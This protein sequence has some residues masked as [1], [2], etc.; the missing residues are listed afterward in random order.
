MVQ[1]K[2]SISQY[3]SLFLSIIVFLVVTTII[4]YFIFRFISRIHR[5]RDLELTTTIE[6]QISTTRSVSFENTTAH[7]CIDIHKSQCKNKDDYCKAF[8]DL[9][10]RNMNINPPCHSK[11]MIKYSENKI[12][13]ESLDD[14]KFID[15]K[16]PVGYYCGYNIELFKKTENM[17]ESIF[18][19][20]KEETPIYL[21]ICV[22]KSE[23]FDD[24]F[25]NGK[26]QLPVKLSTFNL[27]FANYTNNE[28]KKINWI[29]LDVDNVILEMVGINKD[30][31][32]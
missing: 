9:I 18:K 31:S 3:I 21:L 30:F 14:L 32:N 16:N 22:E 17:I 29:L 1:K 27:R 20:L 8:E 4:Q 12:L 25:F 23:N 26:V 7:N 19:V 24:N 2:R 5:Y 13:I 10:E 15:S 28:G 6:P 11:S